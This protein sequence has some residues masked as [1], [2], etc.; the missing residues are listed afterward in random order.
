MYE[1]LAFTYTDWKIIFIEIPYKVVG[2]IVSVLFNNKFNTQSLIYSKIII[3][4][5]G[6]IEY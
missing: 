6:V 1:M 5:H 3:S 2:D 4:V